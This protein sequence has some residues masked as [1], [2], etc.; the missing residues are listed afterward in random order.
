MCS[1]APIAQSNPPNGRP[2]DRCHSCFEALY[3][4]VPFCASKCGYCAFYSVPGAPAAVRCR[5]LDRLQEEFSAGGPRCAS[6]STMFIGGGTPSVL[7]LGE[8]RGLLA[9]IRN[10][11]S[12]LPGVEWTV[13]CNP[14]SLTHY[15]ACLLAE[16]G[17][18][19][20]SLGVQTFAP[21]LRQI[22]MRKGDIS[23]LPETVRLLRE[24]GVAGVN[25]DL[26]YA[27]PGQKI[28][29]WR[30][31]VRQA[32][33]LGIDHLS[34]YALTWEEGTHLARS[35]LPPVDENLEVQMWEMAAQEASAFGLERYEVSNLARPGAECRHNSRIWHGATY[36]GCGPSATSFDGDLRWTNPRSLNAWL[37]QTPPEQDHLPPELR[38][39]EILAFGLRTVEGWNL[40]EFA[41]TTNH[42]ALTL[43]AIPI[44]QLVSEGLLVQNEQSIRPTRKGL[45]FADYVAQTLL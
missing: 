44:D 1:P 29:Q 41:K 10:S 38:A 12:L 9:G 2:P 28:S 30:S 8:L 43:R 31:D 4:H 33:E 16:A 13:E 35:N 15:K 3:V 11:F 18:N 45:L 42:D 37:E 27:I 24:L 23:H 17:V 7:D 5:Y 6:L 34:T 20:I 32:C 39:A 14:G 25:V 21:D 36:L 40:K 22:L 26:I 19:R